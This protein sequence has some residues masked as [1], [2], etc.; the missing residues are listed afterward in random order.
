MKELTYQRQQTTLERDRSNFA[1]PQLPF[2]LFEMAVEYFHIGGLFE[3]R[4]TGD[5]RPI[6]VGSLGATHLNPLGTNHSSEWRFSGALGGGI[7]WQKPRSRIGFRAQ[8]RLWLTFFNTNS[9]I[10]CSSTGRD[11]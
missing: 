8:S 10:F 11:R 5:W 3:P 7:K 6:V 9:Q 4:P 2:T 1:P